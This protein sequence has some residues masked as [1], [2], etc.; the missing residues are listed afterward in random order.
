MTAFV[1]NTT[2][3][4]LPLLELRHRRRARCEDRIRVAKDT[5]LQSLRLHGFDQNRIRRHPLALAIDLTTGMGLPAHP[6]EQAR[7]WEPK[8]LRLRL[9]SIPAAIART[10]R[11]T[12]LQLSDRTGWASIALAAI[13]R[14]RAH[15]RPPG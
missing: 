11:R 14:W 12:I 13:T 2:R 10:C 1:T 9:F 8:R 4:Q 7:R 5:G 3:G 6:D 15:A